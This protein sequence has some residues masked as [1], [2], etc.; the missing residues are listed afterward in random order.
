[1]YSFVTLYSGHQPLT[2]AT[3][4]HQVLARMKLFQLDG[5]I[6]R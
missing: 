4:S 2:Y 6:W 5:V 3:N 1:M